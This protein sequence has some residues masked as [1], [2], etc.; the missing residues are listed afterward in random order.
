MP[1]ATGLS[2][3]S[4]SQVLE[5][6]RRI[7]R[8]NAASAPLKGGDT[9]EL[10][11]FQNS[12]TPQRKVATTPSALISSGTPLRVGI[13][14]TPS[15]GGSVASGLTPLR[16]NLSINGDATSMSSDISERQRLAAVRAQLRSAF[17]QLPAPKNE[18]QIVGPD[19]D[20]ELEVRKAFYSSSFI[21]FVARIK[22]FV[23]A[24]VRTRPCRSRA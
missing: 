21:I 4:S 16:D 10:P 19:M 12:I 13:A 6:A 7:A 17:A 2:S 9:V 15:R 23:A 22:S 11:E 14:G 18:V 24:G 1:L 20:D 3:Y 5:E 8:F